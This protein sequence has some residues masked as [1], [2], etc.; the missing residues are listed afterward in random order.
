MLV[1]HNDIIGTKTTAASRKALPPM[2]STAR[3]LMLLE[4]VRR[5]RRRYLWNEILAQTA[6]GASAALGALVLLLLL[7][8]QILS[9]HWMVALPAGAFGVG[10]YRTVKRLPGS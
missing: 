8:S 3:G 4:V 6:L 9:W 10:L 2:C 7:G 1:F 5:A